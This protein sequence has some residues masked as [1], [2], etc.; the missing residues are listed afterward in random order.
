[1]FVGCEQQ[2]P[3]KQ[4]TKDSESQSRN[5]NEDNIKPQKPQSFS[6]NGDKVQMVYLSK[7]LLI[8]E[9]EYSGYS[10]FIITI[11]KSDGELVGSPINIISKGHYSGSQSVQIETDG[12]YAFN[13]QSE[14]KWTFNIK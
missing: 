3:I 4:Q 2:K 7:G 5:D 11:M 9:T 13:V 14:G 6:G 10:N 8:I 1:M 12:L